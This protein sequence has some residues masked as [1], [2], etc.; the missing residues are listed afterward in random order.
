MKLKTIFRPLV[1]ALA[2][3]L[4]P[5]IAMQ[6]TSEM[7]WDIFDF[8]VMGVLI[9]VAGLAYEFVSKKFGRGSYR[10]ATAI[11]ITTSL[12]IVWANLAVGI[13]GNEDN[14][15][16]LLYFGVIL[17]EIVGSALVRFNPRKMSRVMYA[18]ALA[19]ALVP[20][21]ALLIGRPELKT[22][23]DFIGVAFIFSITIFFALLF[24]ISG[25][26][27]KNSSESNPKT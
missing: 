6:F 27:Y 10:L 8:I 3:L 15:I 20:P 11:A 4:L 7:N 24:F 19:Q 26:L 1:V 25:K 17:I 5:L 13:I 9:F 22:T 14:P 23:G 21:I 12:F 18:T 2:L 16:N